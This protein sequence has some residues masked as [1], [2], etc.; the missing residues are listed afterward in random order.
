MQ[1]PGTK[2]SVDDFT[3]N[4]ASLYALTHYHSDHRRGLRNS[5]T[6]PVLCSTITGNLLTGLNN[7][8]DC[9]ITAIDPEEEIT[10]PEKITIKAFDANHCPGALMFLFKVKNRKY[11]HTGDFRYCTL[12]DSYPELFKDIDTLFIDS[13]YKSEN[14]DYNHPPQDTAIEEIIDLI[15]NNV[16]KTIYLGLYQIGKNKIIQA[17]HDRLGIRTYVNKERSRI[18]SLIGM[19]ESITTNPDESRVK[20]YSMGYFYQY[21]KMRY[22]DH[23]KDSIVIIPSGWSGGRKNRDGFYYIPYSE[24]NSSEELKQFIEKVK[25]LR[26]VETNV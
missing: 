10:L 3:K 15:K 6:R 2:I 23:K 7:I 9:N 12:H 22:P 19:D 21:F 8:P 4:G 1:I 13:T 14:G 16:D 11:L 25:P 18:Y 24:H 5:D 26:V 17:I 20:G